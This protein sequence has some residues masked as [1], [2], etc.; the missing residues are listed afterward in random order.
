MCVCLSSSQIIN[1]HTFWFI[2]YFQIYSAKLGNGLLS[3]TYSTIAD[4]TLDSECTGI[5]PTMFK[6]LISK[7][8]R[9]FSSK[10]QQDAQEFFLHV[11]N[12]IEKHSQNQANPADAFRFTVEDRVECGTSGKVKY[13]RRDEWCL[14]LH[15]PLHLATNIAEVREFEARLKEAES[16]GQKLEPD[17]LVRPRITLQSCLD[18]FAQSEEI[19]QFYS[20]AIGDKTTAKK[21]ARLATMPDFMLLHLKKFT[22]REDWTS[23]KL[24]VAVEVP[25]LLDLS[26]LRSTGKQADEE[27]LPELDKEIPPPPMDEAVIH[28]LADMG[29]P[30]EACK[31]AIFF[32]KNTGL[33]PATQWI[34]EHMGDDD[35][36]APFVPPGTAPAA[37]VAF[38]ADSNGLEMLMGM[39]FNIA[40]A[41]KALKET[42]NNIER[43]ADWIFSHQA[44]IANLDVNPDGTIPVDQPVAAASANTVN[45]APTTRDGESRKYLRLIVL[46]VFV[47]FEYIIHIRVL[48]AEYKL[49]AIISHMGTSSQVGHYVCHIRK[50]NQWVIFNDSKVAVSQNPP[51]ELGYLYLYQRV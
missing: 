30:V 9:E 10:M 45:Q 4:N 20:T 5:A 14:P 42:Q 37:A 50:N 11:L 17:A 2:F 8:H 32:T 51:K 46:S 36:G 38:V 12:Q 47:R 49:T 23:I 41:T 31:R 27:L 3:G 13:T 22:L 1:D 15:I 19:E 6:N 34:M 24:D 35:F 21:T 33:E 44:E 40:Q 39:G 28:Q 16:R 18:R 43:A 29:F 7:N 26:A 48:I 25:D